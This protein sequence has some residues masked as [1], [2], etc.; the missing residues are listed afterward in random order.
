MSFSIEPSTGSTGPTVTSE[1]VC[2]TGRGNFTRTDYKASITAKGW[3][4][5]ESVT[6]KTTLV[7]AD[8]PDGATA[9]LQTARKLNKKIISYVE[10]DQML[11]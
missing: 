7:A 6:L 11:A 4:F 8:N 9:K 2:L 3:G 10:L 5:T 1:V